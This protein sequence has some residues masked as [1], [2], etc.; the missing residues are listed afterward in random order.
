M[1]GLLSFIEPVQFKRKKNEAIERPDQRRKLF[2]RVIFG[3]KGLHSIESLP[4]P[5][6]TR[7]ENTQ[8]TPLKG[9]VV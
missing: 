7:A 1:L 5:L 2:L 4:S 9:A 3:I 8:T 6:C